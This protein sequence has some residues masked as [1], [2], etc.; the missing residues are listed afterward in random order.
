MINKSSIKDIQSLQQKKF[1]DEYNKFIAE[2]PKVVNEL[3]LQAYFECEMVYCTAEWMENTP[4]A[5]LDKVSSKIEIVKDFELQKISA[6]TVAN[7]VLSVFY[8]KQVN[9]NINIANSLTLLLE[10]VQDPGNLGTIIRIADWFGIKQIICSMATADCYNPKVV[11]STM[12]S[13]GRV[14]IIYT[15]VINFLNEH[16][17]AK[18][19]AAVLGGKDIRFVGKIKDGII[20]LGNESKGLSKEILAMADEKFSIQKIG[21][22]ESLNVAVA[23]GIILFAI[24]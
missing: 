17:S 13:L 7:Q 22:A 12:A 1:R 9:K 5:I 4:K 8:K 24:Q 14:N 11:Q 15:D 18:K 10:D 3:L 16:T 21:E 19:Y 6:L 2:G 20:L 23:A